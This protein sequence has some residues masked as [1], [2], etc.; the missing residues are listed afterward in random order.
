MT[1]TY[2]CPFYSTFADNIDEVRC[3]KDFDRNGRV[4]RVTPEI[5]TQCWDRQKRKRRKIKDASTSKVLEET[6]C[7]CR[8]EH[9]SNWFCL[10]K[11]PTPKKLEHGLK[12]CQTCQDRLTHEKV[13]REAIRI[14][15]Q[16]YLMCGAKEVNDRKKGLMVYSTNKACPH[17]GEWITPH[18]CET[19]KCHLFKKVETKVRD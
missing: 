3:S 9:E 13:Q 11:P 14:E 16:R 1:R 10:L 12:T 5:C 4:Y 15:V 7:L 2:P 19:A 17:K 8:Y 18:E 6:P